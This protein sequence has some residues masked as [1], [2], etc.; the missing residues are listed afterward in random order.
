MNISRENIDALSAVVKIEV[1]KSDYQG[2]VDKTLKSYA[3][4]VQLPGFRVG[5]VPAS[6]VTKMYGKGILVEEINKLVFEELNKYVSE[7]KLNVLGE[8]L[9]SAKQD[10]IDFDT[11][12][13]FTFSFDIALAP[14]VQVNVSNKLNVP[15]YN[16]EVDQAMIDEQVIG[17]TN[18][19]GTNE[20]VQA[21]SEGSMIKADLFEVDA[22]GNV[23]DGGISSLGTMVSVKVIKDDAEK[24]K[25][26]GAGVGDSIVVNI[27]KA[28]PNVSEKS[29]LLKVSKEIA[30][31]ITSDFRIDISEITDYKSAELNEDLFKKLYGESVTTEAQFKDKIK[32]EI[33]TAL[34]YE[35][36]FKFALD[37]KK[38]L[39][40]TL[41]IELPE[42]FLKRWLIA[43]NEGKKEITPEILEKELPKFF[44]ELKWNLVKN[45]IIKEAE[46]K[47]DADD[48]KKVALKTAKMQ[49]M[50]Y[51]LNNVADEHLESYAME[52]MKN[53]EQGRQYAEEAVQ[54]KVLAFIKEKA[55]IESKSISR[56]AFNK[57]WE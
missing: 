42:V 23:V 12:E 15:Y 57:L 8:P 35:S 46:L 41:N 31:A 48:V 45:T 9:P 26:I 56:E 36:E 38:E 51:G 14:E 10:V 52:M 3:K 4:K 29:Y 27:D 49:F 24:A 44:E 6:M 2:R 5:K 33:A 7:N 28:Y 17:T 47:I 25:F 32:E 20:I 53:E 1:A 50:Q 13:N 55:T 18:R 43:A 30:E 34:A 54:N 16:I 11:Q 21:V 37:A 40:S 19:F 39:M 22:K